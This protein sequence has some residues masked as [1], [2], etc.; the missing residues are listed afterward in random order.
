MLFKQGDMESY[1]LSFNNK[2]GLAGQNW[3]FTVSYEVDAYYLKLF[4]YFTFI[5]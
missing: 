2:R 1:I 4:R 5:F 3:F